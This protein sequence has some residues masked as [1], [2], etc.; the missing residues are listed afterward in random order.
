METKNFFA[1]KCGGTKAPKGE[2]LTPKK[3]QAGAIAKAT[4]FGLTVIW[5]TCPS[6]GS[7]K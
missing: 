1:C 7:A 2:W 4:E 5:I 3:T 6:C